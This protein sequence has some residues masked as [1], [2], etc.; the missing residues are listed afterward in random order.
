MSPFAINVNDPNDPGMA[1]LNLLAWTVSAAAVAGLL[2]VGMNMALQF[3][4]GDPGE[5]SE[6]SRGLLIVGGAC[7]L[8]ATAGPIVQFLSI[9]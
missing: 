1:L 9:Y 6:H 7:V 2:V 3:R 4:R 8:G 5:F